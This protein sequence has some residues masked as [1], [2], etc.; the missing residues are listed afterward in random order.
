M[1]RCWFGEFCSTSYYYQ[2][3]DGMGEAGAHS[4]FR[5]KPVYYSTA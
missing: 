3:S 2:V 1:W 4:D 5:D